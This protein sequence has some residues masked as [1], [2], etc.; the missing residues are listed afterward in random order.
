MH[1]AA[2][3]ASAATCTSTRMPPP[4]QTGSPAAVVDA[5]HAHVLLHPWHPQKP[6]QRPHRRHA[7]PWL[8]LKSVALH[9]TPAPR[10]ASAPV[11]LLQAGK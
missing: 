8:P 11:L 6:A 5:H 1:A 10:E 3:K 2:I 4:S 9:P 7:G